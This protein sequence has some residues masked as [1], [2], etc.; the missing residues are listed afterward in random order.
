MHPSVSPLKRTLELN[1]RLF[2]N[3]LDGVTDAMALKRPSAETN[4]VAFVAVH[5]L[6]ARYYLARAVGLT[7]ESPFKELL[8]GA[9]GIDDI[10]EYPNLDS[11]RDAWSDVSSQL[12]SRLEGLSDV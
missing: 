5:V 4:H 3:C 1:T 12:S 9:K 8:E 6:D 2:L 11:V 7:I 10:D